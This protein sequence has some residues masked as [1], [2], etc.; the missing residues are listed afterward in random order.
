MSDRVVGA[1]AAAAVQDSPAREIRTAVSHKDAAQRRREIQPAAGMCRRRKKPSSMSHVAKHA[2][3]QVR[4]PKH[5][6]AFPL[7]PQSQAATIGLTCI[8]LDSVPVQLD[9]ASDSAFIRFSFFC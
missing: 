9:Y 1:G 3:A 7:L 8:T 4:M 5:F 6:K 2:R